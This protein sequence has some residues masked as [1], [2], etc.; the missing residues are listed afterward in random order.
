MIHLSMDEG[1]EYFKG[2]RT[3][4]TKN[5]SRPDKIGDNYC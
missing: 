3:T 5:L 4:G 1:I 2:I